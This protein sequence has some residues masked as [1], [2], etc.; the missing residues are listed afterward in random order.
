MNEITEIRDAMLIVLPKAVYHYRAPKSTKAPY[1]V[2]AEDGRGD[3]THANNSMVGQVIQGTVDYFTRS[4]YDPN[5]D[6]IQRAMTIKHIV[7]RLAS[8]QFEEETGL[9]HY[10]WIWE[11]AI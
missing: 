9:I 5:I 2:W 6:R 4:E 8:I 1:I 7:F 10:E 3:T 11:V